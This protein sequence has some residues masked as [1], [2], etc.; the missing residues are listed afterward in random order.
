MGIHGHRFES[1]VDKL[2]M[3]QQTKVI[4]LLIFL[5][6]DFHKV[7]LTNFRIRIVRAPPP[8]PQSP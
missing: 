7:R 6:K 8:P 4:M 3:K 5:L 1:G 2:G